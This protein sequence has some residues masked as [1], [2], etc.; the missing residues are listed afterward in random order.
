MLD[1]SKAFDQVCR[2][3][4]LAKLPKFWFFSAFVTWTPGFFTKRTIF[5]EIDGTLPQ[6]IPVGVP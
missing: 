2:E 5:V 1:I 3:G 6:P 4:P